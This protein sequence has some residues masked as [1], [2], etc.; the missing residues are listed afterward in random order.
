[1]G[2]NANLVCTGFV[3]FIFT[4][5]VIVVIKVQWMFFDNILDVVQNVRVSCN[6]CN[7]LLS[8][9]DILDARHRPV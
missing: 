2:K 3:F 4:C 7:I 8:H 5:V 6:K 1:M 9:E